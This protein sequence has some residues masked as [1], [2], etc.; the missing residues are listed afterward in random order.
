[1]PAA[2]PVL[3]CLKLGKR[4]AFMEVAG[5]ERLQRMLLGHGFDQRYVT[6]CQVPATGEMVTQLADQYR[7]RAIAIV[8]DATANPTNV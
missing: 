7:C 6:V 5:A 4:I 8:T 2:S 1:M 3:R